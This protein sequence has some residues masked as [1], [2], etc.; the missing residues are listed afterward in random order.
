M[1]NAPIHKTDAVK[2][3]FSSGTQHKH[4]QAFIPAYSP[5]LNAIE[6]TFNTWS[7]Y[8]KQHYEGAGVSALGKLIDDGSKVITAA[9]CQEWH[10]K[11]MRTLMDDCLQNKPLVD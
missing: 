11:V 8:I 2:E 6:Y 10:H 3:V 4:Q 1:D 7:Q 5:A 9:K